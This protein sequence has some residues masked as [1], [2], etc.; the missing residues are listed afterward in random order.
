MKDL[1]AGWSDQIG[2]VQQCE[3]TVD[4]ALEKV[5]GNRS[6]LCFV[7]CKPGPTLIEDGAGEPASGDETSEE[8]ARKLARL[9]RA[10]LVQ[11]GATASSEEAI[12]ALESLSTDVCDLVFLQSAPPATLLRGGRQDTLPSLLIGR[13]GIWPIRRILL[14]M[15]G[16]ATDGPTIEWGVRL[17][18]RSGSAVTILVVLPS[19]DEGCDCRASDLADILAQHTTPGRYMRQVMKRMAARNIES[20]LRVGQGLPAWQVRQEVARR[21]YDLVIT[22]IEPAGRLLN[23]HLERLIEPLQQ[24]TAAPILVARFPASWLG[25]PVKGN[26]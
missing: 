6:S 18:E 3:V 2:P 1:F 25:R 16:E 26:I 23:R 12:G 20:I 5:R 4:G 7:T 13:T 8:Y 21:S 10:Q 24:W 22:S 15:R 9:M 19:M 17:A 11:L 14:L